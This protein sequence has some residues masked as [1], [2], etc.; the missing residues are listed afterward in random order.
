MRAAEE[1]WASDISE[2]RAAADT[3]R[4]EAAAAQEEAKAAKASS[5]D[6]QNSSLAVSE[7]EAAAKAALD[8][9]KE[10]LEQEKASSAAFSAAEKE[11][12][13]KLEAAET[14]RDAAIARVGKAEAARETLEK[15]LKMAAAVEKANMASSASTTSTNVP[16]NPIMEDIYT[17]MYSSLQ[18][19]D[20]EATFTAKKLNK[21]IR[22]TLKQVG[23]SCTSAENI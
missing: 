15:E 4:V 7:A 17:I 2:A 10:K 14:D 23:H 1:K 16:I 12:L 3:A 21:E 5:I 8:E 19:A 6:I 13:Q 20:S 22:N 18:L 9:M 11:A